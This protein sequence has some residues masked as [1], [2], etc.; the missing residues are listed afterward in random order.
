MKKV[1]YKEVTL[2][3]GKLIIFSNAEEN[4]AEELIKYFNIVGG[5]SD[6]L[7]FGKDEF[8]LSIEREKEHINSMNLD[9][10]A[11][12][13]VARDGAEIISVAQLSSYKRKRISHNAVYSISVK[14][15][16]W[17]CGIGRNMTDLII[18]F[19]KNN[20][21][22]KNISLSVNSN[23]K[24]AVELYKQVGFEFVGKHK[25]NFK[26]G[27]LYIDELLMDLYL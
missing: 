16:Y 12:I 21:S 23:N 2:S 6:N 15:K 24:S 3:N 18:D 22:L 9:D 14:K 11:L 19:A 8:G 26:L 5:E 10:N 1:I 7:L 20:T 27:E 17:R 25:R 13:L 4:D